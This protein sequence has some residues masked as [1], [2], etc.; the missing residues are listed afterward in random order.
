MGLQLDGASQQNLIIRY[1]PAGEKE[2]RKE[3]V[4]GLDLAAFMYFTV[5]N[6]NIARIID[7]ASHKWVLILGRFTEGRKVLDA[8]AESVRKERLIPIIFD[9]NRPHDRDLIET[10]LLLAGMSAFVV[11]DISDPKSTPLE[12][13]AIAT[14]YGVPIFPVMKKGSGGFSLFAPLRRFRWVFEPMSYKDEDD[15]KK[16]LPNEVFGPARDEMDRLAHLKRAVE[17]ARPAREDGLQ[18]K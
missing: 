13:Y 16:R 4:D 15:L 10:V 7:A 12:L 17:E 6:E 1:R 3:L 14:N 11:V 8:I 5:S 18:E 2:E 9:F